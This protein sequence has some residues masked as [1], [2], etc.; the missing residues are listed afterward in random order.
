MKIETYV[1]EGGGDDD[2][3]TKLLEQNEEEVELVWHE[4]VQYN[5]NEHACR[6]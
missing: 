3:S 2:T 5:R 4:L 6:H 1:N